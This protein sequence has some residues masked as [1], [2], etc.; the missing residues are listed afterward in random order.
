MIRYQLAHFID[1]ALTRVQCAP[2]TH[3][4]IPKTAMPT[5]ARSPHYLLGVILVLASG[6]VL[7]TLGV[8]LR[9]VESASGWQILFYRS[10]AF[11]AM[12]LLII[13]VRYRG[14]AVAAFRSIG[15]RGFVVALFLASSSL[16]YVFAMLNTTVA[17][18]TFIVST[19]P[20]MAAC[21]GW[22]V[23]REPVT[24]T[25]WIAIA[26]AMLGVV[27]MVVDGMETDSLIGVGL[28]L[29]VALGTAGMLVTV[30]GASEIDMIPALV[31]AGVATGFFTACMVSDFQISTHD[32]TVSFLLGAGQY[33]IGFVLITAGT[34]YVPVAEVALLSLV[35]TVLAPIWAWW[36]A[37]EIPSQLTIAG[38]I[39]V[40]TAALGR[41]VVGLREAR[42]GASATRAKTHP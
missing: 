32:L 6:A 7:S 10:I 40:L 26:V 9:Q 39:I 36:G 18:A 16:L 29:G 13:T 27:L 2:R 19:T 37:G 28:A 33:A 21:L 14:G 1:V 25:T 12:L 4:T 17:N 11:T 42:T 23:L 35:E 38:G 8:G 31:I 20:F 5:A 22:L 24:L 3:R 41:G 15:R 30:R 34:R